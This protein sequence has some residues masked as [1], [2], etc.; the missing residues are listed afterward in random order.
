M[1]AC[2]A[3]ED[4]WLSNPM[5]VAENFMRRIEDLGMLPLTYINPK[6]IQD[7]FDSYLQYIDEYPVDQFRNGSPY[8]FYLEGYEDEE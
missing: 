4:G 3:E 1:L 8:S 5:C 7:G 2:N 6:A